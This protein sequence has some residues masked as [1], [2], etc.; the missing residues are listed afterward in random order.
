MMGST[1]VAV[2]TAA[3]ALAA[4]GS[5]AV[6]T[7]SA[8]HPS[9][10]RTAHE[11]PGRGRVSSISIAPGA[12]GAEV[13]I[14]IDS[15]ISVNHFVIESPTRLVVDLGGASL[16]LRNSAYDGVARGPIRNLRLSQYRADTVRLV[17]DLDAS[18]LDASQLDASQLDASRRYTVAR[19][20]ASLRLVVNGGS[21]AFAR[22]QTNGAA[23][24]PAAAIVASAAG[25]LDAPVTT[26]LHSGALRTS[27]STK[28][29]PK[30][31]TAEDTQVAKA[32]QNA[33]AK[34]EAK[35]EAAYAAGQKA[36]AQADHT[37]IS[38]A[39]TQKMRVDVDRADGAAALAQPA[40]IVRRQQKP[41]I[42]VSYDGT[43]IRDVIA[44]FATFSNRTII[45]GK[46]V[47]G[48]V[49]ADISDKPW[50]VALQAI[51]QAQGLAATED[52]SGI[53]T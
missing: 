26:P 39:S 48:T 13:T 27:D 4:H 11:I 6:R 52:A 22:W 16:A 3:L 49:T 14:T 2:I 25:R 45:V 24:A 46:D 15:A 37:P 38:I 23:S 19:N 29:K 51:L 30:A 42:T 33:A 31:P 28:V 18:Q 1:T 5:A 34:A 10:A 12:T 43:D 47:S 9:N 44:A 20:G 41:R 40:P 35:A 21:T 50:D 8:A 7:G 17:I 53:I 32:V 36:D